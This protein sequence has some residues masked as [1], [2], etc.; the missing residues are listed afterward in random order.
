MSRGTMGKRE[1]QIILKTDE[2]NVILELLG[3]DGKFTAQIKRL[4]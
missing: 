1:P 3:R 4:G 2:R